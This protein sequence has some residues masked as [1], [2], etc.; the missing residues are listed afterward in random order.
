[1]QCRQTGAKCAAPSFC[2]FLFVWVCGAALPIDKI[3]SLIIPSSGYYDSQATKG[4]NT[5][6]ACHTLVLDI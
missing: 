6:T 3:L 1:M 5:S 2:F 4:N